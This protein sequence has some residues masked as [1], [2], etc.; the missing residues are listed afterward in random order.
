LALVQVSQAPAVVAALEAVQA[1]LVA[2]SPWMQRACVD[3]I[4]AH[5]TLGVL[6]LDSGADAEV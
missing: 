5:L 4:T 6:T 3:A 1:A 2:H